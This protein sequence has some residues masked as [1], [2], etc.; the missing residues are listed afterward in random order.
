MYISCAFV[1]FINEQTQTHFNETAEKEVIVMT[2]LLPEYEG[3]GSHSSV[4]AAANFLGCGTV[5]MIMKMKALQFCDM[6]GTT[7]SRSHITEHFN[8]Q[9][10]FSFSDSTMLRYCLM[11][12][13]L[14]ALC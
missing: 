8:P 10:E 11:S 5:L 6:S 14:T 1:G 2:H 13:I 3:K 4:A 9:V 12:D 7:H